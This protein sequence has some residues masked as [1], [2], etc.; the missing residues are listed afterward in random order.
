MDVLL[1]VVGLVLQAIS[2]WFGVKLSVDPLE[3]QEQRKR[4]KWYFIAILGVGLPLSSVQQWRSSNEENAL[5]A[6]LATIR[7][8]TKQTSKS[9]DIVAQQTKVPPSVTVNTA[10]P[11]VHVLPPPAPLPSVAPPDLSLS[12]AT[13]KPVDGGIEITVALVNRGT[14]VTIDASLVFD[15]TDPATGTA[16][17]VPS[18]IASRWTLS[19]DQVVTWTNTLKL[20]PAPVLERIKTGDALVRVRLSAAYPAE[21]PRERLLVEGKVDLD[22]Q[23]VNVSTNRPEP[24]RKRAL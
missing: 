2:T 19:R 14:A 11:V 6:E 15:V 8:A 3:T 7:E 17:E 21:N 10:P 9:V 12:T 22:R 1:F 5:R 4:Y 18:D 23:V 13:A 16:L 24:L 20:A